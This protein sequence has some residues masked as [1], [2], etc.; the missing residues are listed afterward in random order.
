MRPAAVESFEHERNTTDETESISLEHP[1]DRLKYHIA[2]NGGKI[3]KSEFSPDGVA[4]VYWEEGGQ[5][6]RAWTSWPDADYKINW[7]AV[8]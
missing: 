4:F 7:K 1:I 2:R 6:F 5:Q 8:G 3:L